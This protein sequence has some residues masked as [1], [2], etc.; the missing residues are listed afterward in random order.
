MPA[1]R[2][3]LAQ[4]RCEKGDWAG[5]LRRAEANMAQAA[6]AG[7]DV[8]V[9]PEMALSGYCDPRRFPAAAQPSDCAALDA[10]VALTARYGIAAS[11]GFMEANPGGGPY[12]AQLLAQDGRRVGQYRKVHLGEDE[13]LY[14]PGTET[15]VFDLRVGRGVVRCGLAI[16]ADSD[17]PAL[18]AAYAGAGARLILH[19]SAPGLYTPRTDAASWRAG[20]DWYRGYL[21]A[22]LP[23]IA[24]RHGLYIAVATQTGHTVDEDFPGGSFLFGPEGALLAESGGP[25]EMLLICEARL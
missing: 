8:V 13:E 1:I 7:C 2:I 5:N 10:F 12:I 15:P 24:R 22:R 18:F 14:T 23:P 25:E 11:A 3:G 20:Y 6:A 21:G 19:S 16:C 4:M 9:L 17:D